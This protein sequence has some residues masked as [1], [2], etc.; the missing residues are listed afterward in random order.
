MAGLP[1][2][3]PC[4]CRTAEP[5]W[6][7]RLQTFLPSNQCSTFT[8]CQGVTGN[9]GWPP[10][11]LRSLWD[12]SVATRLTS[13]QKTKIQNLGA[14]E[15]TPCPP[16]CGHSLEEATE[17]AYLGSVQ[18]ISGRCQPDIIRRIGIASTAMHSM[19]KVWRQNCRQNF[20]CTRVVYCSAMWWDSMTVRHPTAH[21]HSS[22]QQKLATALILVGGDSQDARAIYGSTRSAMVHPLAFVLN[23]L[24]LVVVATTGWRNGPLLPT[25]SDDADDELEMMVFSPSPCLRSVCI[26]YSELDAVKMTGTRGKI[27][28]IWWN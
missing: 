24:R 22:Q 5:V 1:V 12:N 16:V 20:A 19:N 7:T 27:N 11:C 8:L 6:S 23:G 3:L 13:W 26:Q 18:S 9:D 28:T 25:R 4:L 2:P 14:G 17:F 21:Y 10:W 15:S